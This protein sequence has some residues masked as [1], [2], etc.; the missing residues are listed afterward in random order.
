MTRNVLITGG[1]RGIGAACAQKLYDAGCN[2][3]VVYAADDVSAHRFAEGKDMSR[4]LIVKADVSSY[5]AMQNAAAEAKAKFGSVDILINNAGI[6][7]QKMMNDITEQ[8]WDRMFDV[9][10]KGCF[11]CVKAV[12]DGMIHNKFGRIIN[13][14]SMWGQVGASCEVHYSAAKAAVIG[15][16]KALAKELA[17]SGITVNCIAPGVIDTDMN[18]ILDAD[19]LAAL[20]EETPVG[21]LGT[22]EDVANA[23]MFFIKEESGFVTGQVLGVN[24]GFVI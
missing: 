2:V 17:P 19:T 15:F 20:A 23:V 18:K 10:V 3:V 4:L 24:G 7:C 11:N 14:S 12:M 21:R 13:I 5:E 6:A 1:T 16:T 8:D 22:A 9:N